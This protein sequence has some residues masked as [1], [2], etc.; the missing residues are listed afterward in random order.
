RAA[1]R[2][3]RWGGRVFVPSM[4]ADWGRM[5]DPAAGGYDPRVVLEHAAA[6]GYRRPGAVEPTFLDGAVALAHVYA[7]EEWAPPT[8]DAPAA[9]TPAIRAA[10]AMLARTPVLREQVKALVHAIHPGRLGASL[11][12]ELPD[13]TLAAVHGSSR[14]H[15][16]A[17]RF[18]TLWSTVDCPFGLAQS[19]VHEMAHQKLRALGLPVEGSG[20]LVATPPSQL[21]PSPILARD[22]PMSAV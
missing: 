11:R 14:S 2:E 21:Y 7:G 4:T 1:R 20:V 18:G 9:V 12:H 3:A 16:L 6:Q 8:P 22:R 17:H 15:S 5:A 19:I 13:G 10:D